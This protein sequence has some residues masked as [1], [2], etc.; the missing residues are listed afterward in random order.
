MKGD[1]N[2]LHN[3][4]YSYLEVEK[5]HDVLHPIARRNKFATFTSTEDS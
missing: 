3:I 5:N 2:I 4:N 1:F